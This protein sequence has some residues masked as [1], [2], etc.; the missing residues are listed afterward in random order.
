MKA[1]CSPPLKPGLCSLHTDPVEIDKL[2]D[3]G[4]RRREATADNFLTDE[5]PVA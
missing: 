3:G 5:I 4:I 1:I 2:E